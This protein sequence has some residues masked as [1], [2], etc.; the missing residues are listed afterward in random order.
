V[1]LDRT[2]YSLLLKQEVAPATVTAMFAFLTTFLEEAFIRNVIITVLINF[3][4]TICSHN[5]IINNYGRKLSIFPWTRQKVSSKFIDDRG[6]GRQK[7]FASPVIERCVPFM[8][9]V[10]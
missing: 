10:S 5:A 1:T 4:I 8:F 7:S 9:I 3:I 2:F 6:K